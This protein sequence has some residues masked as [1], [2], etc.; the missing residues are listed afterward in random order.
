[1]P[2]GFSPNFK[3]PIEGL[4]NWNGGRNS[5]LEARTTKAAVATLK[6]W[7]N[8]VVLNFRIKTEAKRIRPGRTN[9]SDLRLFYVAANFV[10]SDETLKR[11]VLAVFKFP[12]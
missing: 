1:M 5:D 4:E 3:K 12:L 7:R 10:Y 6:S 2:N 8:R 9:E 11:L